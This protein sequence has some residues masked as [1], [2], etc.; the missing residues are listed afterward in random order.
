MCTN[1]DAIKTLTLTQGCYCFPG[2]KCSNVLE[3]VDTHKTKV[4][5]TQYDTS[6]CSEELIQFRTGDSRLYFST[7]RIAVIVIRHVIH[8][9]DEKPIETDAFSSNITYP[10]HYVWEKPQSNKKLSTSR[11]SKVTQRDINLIYNLFS[12]GY[13]PLLLFLDDP[14]SLEFMERAQLTKA[15]LHHNFT[16]DFIGLPMNGKDLSF[17]DTDGDDADGDD[18]DGDG[19]EDIMSLKILYT[20]NLKKL[21]GESVA[22]SFFDGPS[23]RNRLKDIAEQEKAS[24]GGSFLNSLQH[25]S[26]PAAVAAYANQEPRVYNVGTNDDLRT[27]EEFK[28]ISSSWQAGMSSSDGGEAMWADS[29]LIQASIRVTGIAP[30]L[31]DSEIFQNS[32]G[33]EEYG[34]RQLTGVISSAIEYKNPTDPSKVLRFTLLNYTSDHYNGIKFKYRDSSDNRGKKATKEELKWRSVSPDFKSLPD[35]LKASIYLNLFLFTMK[36]MS[37]TKAVNKQVP[38]YNKKDITDGA[39]TGF[40]LKEM[41]LTPIG[42]AEYVESLDPA[43]DPS[44]WLR[45]I[46]TVDTGAPLTALTLELGVNTVT[47]IINSKKNYLMYRVNDGM[48]YLIPRIVFDYLGKKLEI[49]GD[50]ATFDRMLVLIEE[51][52]VREDVRN[53]I[54]AINAV[55][56]PLSINKFSHI[57]ADADDPTVTITVLAEKFFEN[58]I[59]SG[60]KKYGKSIG[61]DYNNENAL[62]IWCD[63][64]IDNRIKYYRTNIL[65]PVFYPQIPEETEIEDDEAGEDEIT[66][67]E[68]DDDDIVE[69]IVEEFLGC[70]DSMADEGWVS[71]YLNQPGFYKVVRSPG[72]G[73]CFFWSI[74]QALFF[75]ENKK[76][77]VVEDDG[78]GNSKRHESWELLSKSL[79]DETGKILTLHDYNA[80]V[81]AYNGYRNWR[82]ARALIAS[83]KFLTQKI[84]HLQQRGD[85]S[86]KDYARFQTISEFLASL[87]QSEFSAYGTINFKKSLFFATSATDLVNNTA[88]MG[89][90]VKEYWKKRVRSSVAKSLLEFEYEEDELH[91]LRHNAGFSGQ[92]TAKKCLGMLTSANVEAINVAIVDDYEEEYDDY[93]EEDDEEEYEEEYEEEEYE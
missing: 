25:T 57:R 56:C 21:S 11:S 13:T 82:A 78:K 62:E 91:L 74:A 36:N 79:R 42:V 26:S 71:R 43:F 41:A 85:S 64:T 84:N 27:F 86:R 22:P 17:E 9:T 48:L 23:G 15:A 12:H 65:W 73:N 45:V 10:F 33:C 50:R 70:N 39:Y 63:M 66:V 20:R 6:E 75:E 55:P 3:M 92:S 67:E 51:P 69:R 54:G 38:T 46:E 44:A 29:T 47:A 4:K 7:G 31:F 76:M 81:E 19:E 5:G 83:N 40:L 14:G 18:A 60:I 88:P 80:L 24:L 52:G 53:Y 58:I 30:I 16:K 28:A 59:V 8:T 61:E 77:V 72:D 89:M 35:T 34:L 37:T 68:E 90:K 2:G 1:I 49:T 32:Q 93:E 87:D